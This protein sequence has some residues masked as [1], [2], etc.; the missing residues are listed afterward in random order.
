[1]SL[2]QTATHRAVHSFGSVLC[3]QPLCSRAAYLYPGRQEL[4]TQPAYLPC[5]GWGRQCQLG[6][7]C[8]V[9]LNVSLFS[10]ILLT[11]PDIPV[12]RQTELAFL[13]QK[14]PPQTSESLQLLDSA[15][16]RL[17]L[18]SLPF[19]HYFSCLHLLLKHPILRAFLLRALLSLIQPDNS[20]P[21]TDQQLPF[22]LLTKILPYFEMCFEDMNIARFPY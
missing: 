9:A 3:K 19:L 4:S 18:W 5:L 1:M 22:H 14:S 6:A 21:C 8:T 11:C 2:Q 13:L 7:A 17:L 15:T 20:W 12:V 16:H 10:K